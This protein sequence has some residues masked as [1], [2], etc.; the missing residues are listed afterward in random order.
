M[1]RLACNL[2]FVGRRWC[3]CSE[4]WQSRISAT[5]WRGLA[6]LEPCRRLMVSG[7][8][9]L[10][11]SPAVLTPDG[12]CILVAAASSVKLCSAVTGEVVS[13]LRGHTQDVTA[14]VLDPADDM[15]VMYTVF[16]S[17]NHTLYLQLCTKHLHAL[18]HPFEVLFRYIQRA[19]MPQSGIG[20]CL[21]GTC[22]LHLKLGFLS[23]AW[24]AAP[25]EAPV[26]CAQHHFHTT[27]YNTA[28]HSRWKL[29]SLPA[30]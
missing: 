26:H 30:M 3:R 10:N 12:K 14:T 19:W 8:G 20:T 1:L 9:P 28:G 5:E 17:N 13:N 22:W 27:L 2:G 18:H 24:Y 7:G 21:L 16:V 25:S 11:L 4:R 6:S 15:K 23:K 29:L